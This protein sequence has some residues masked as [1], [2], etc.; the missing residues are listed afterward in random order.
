MRR[1]GAPQPCV[2]LN[3]CRSFRL[4]LPPS[5]LA[6]PQADSIWCDSGDTGASPCL[7][8]RLLIRRMEL[9]SQL[10]AGAAAARCS[11][12]RS[13]AEPLR[14]L[15]PLDL[16]HLC[17]RP[18]G[19]AGAGDDGGAP[20]GA[21]GKGA[22]GGGAGAHAGGGG[23]GA[24]GGNGANGGAN[25]GA[26]SGGANVPDSFIC[27]LSQHVMTDPVVT[28]GDARRRGG[29]A[30]LK[31]GSAAG[32]P[33]RPAALV[34]RGAA[35]GA[36]LHIFITHSIINPFR[37]PQAASPTTAPRLRTGSSATAPTR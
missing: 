29:R 8:G 1:I 15:P 5:V 6:T 17:Q 31:V 9:E 11:A 4:L 2:P 35:A 19:G 3:P 28:P 18:R 25:G 7:G 20:G 12:A 10:A 34:A 33:Q 13:A 24:A 23:A 16:P 22:A 26:N 30:V 27:P 37:N 32:I 21:N 36:F 14:A